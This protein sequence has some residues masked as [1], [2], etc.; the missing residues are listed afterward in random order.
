MLKLGRDNSILW[1]HSMILSLGSVTL[2]AR[3]LEGQLNLSAHVV[4]FAFARLDGV[5]CRFHTQRLDLPQHLGAHALVDPQ[6]TER[7]AQLA[8][9]QMRL[10]VAI[11]S[12]AAFAIADAQFASTVTAAGKAV[13]QRRA[14]AD[15]PPH[16]RQTLAIGVVGHHSLVPL[17][18]LPRDVPFVMVGNK[19]WP[20]CTRSLIRS[21]SYLTSGEGDR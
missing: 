16:Y 6:C 17:V 12:A 15:G 20:L 5:K 21:T 7:D 11:I 3:L 14:T 1:V 18:L 9:M 19:Y 4:Y 2:V 13:E 8:S 10:A